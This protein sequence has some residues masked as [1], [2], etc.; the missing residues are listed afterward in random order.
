MAT[1]STNVYAALEAARNKS[2][3]PGKARGNEKVYADC[4]PFEVVAFMAK[5]ETEYGKPFIRKKGG[6][7][8]IGTEGVRLAMENPA[9]WEKAV[10]ALAKV[11]AGG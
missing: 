5:G 7:F 10:L 6:F 9:D 11:I 4:G 3:K 2:A 8:G 1:H